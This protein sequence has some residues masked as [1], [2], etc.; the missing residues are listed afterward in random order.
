MERSEGLILWL[1]LFAYFVIL[2]SA[3]LSEP[4]WK[5][6][7]RA[8]LAVSL[9]VA[10]FGVGQG[11]RL[12]FLLATSGTR[13][14][15]TFGNPAFL[16]GYLLFHIA[17]AL[18]LFFQ[19]T[20]KAVKIY[21]LAL[22]VL[23]TWVIFATETRG[24]AVGLAAGILLAS[25]L[26]AW[27]N[28]QNK[29]VRNWA[30]GIIILVIL[31]GGALYLGRGS[32]FVKNSPILRRLASISLSER[33]AQTRLATWRAGWQG[34]REH[35]VLGVGMENF[36]IVFNKN[37]PTIIYE[38]EG[39]Q[40]WFDRAH[41]VIFDR[42]V[43]TGALGLALYLVFLFYPVWL[44]FKVYR[45]DPKKRNGAI[46]FLAL[47]IAY[48]IQDLFI[49]ETI[50]T[51]VLLFFTMAFF[52]AS[53]LPKDAPAPAPSGKLAYGIIAVIYAVLLGPVLWT[54]NIL[55]ARANLTA[56]AALRIE[57]KAEN[58][59]PITEQ[60]K[61][62]L[63]LGTYGKKEY[64]V[65]YIDFVG[66]QLANL[67]TV[68]EAVKP[69]VADIDNQVA[70]QLA[71]YPYDAKNYLVAMRHYN[72]TNAIDPATVIQRLEKA[73]S[74][75]EKLKNLTPS[76]PHVY[77]EAGYTHLYLAR[78]YKEQ[79]QLDLSDE[80]FKIAEAMFNQT[81]ALNPRVTES[82]RN[83]IMLY[84]SLG[85]EDKVEE[86]IKKM[87][88]VKVL[89]TDDRDYAS[90]SDLAK[91]SNGFR[92]VEY[93]SLERLKLN[94][95]N[96]NAWIDLALSYAYRGQKAKAIEIANKITSFGDAYAGEVDTFIKNVNSGYYNQKR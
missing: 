25:A 76:R 68:S 38:D 36:N 72:Y 47:I 8:S 7:L 15:A 43:T 93:L 13:V 60:Y 90:L 94:E 96:V 31:A 83:L 79:N 84:F 34:W 91:S 51:Y 19:T 58:F 49:F 80:H 81:V 20:S 41:N 75:F 85:Q 78:Y 4:A 48:F 57:E 65:K 40:V 17:F 59:F 22:P 45:D 29:R 37:F 73:L 54:V 14:D 11:L 46:I 28:R 2:V 77:Q 88:E 12:D 23:F 89:G 53:V 24:A 16:A 32:A 52:A 71:E 27:S 5:N 30:V 44:F 39:S 82:F 62:T 56:A 69:V 42:G 33:T 70:L 6:L 50:V 9:L 18:Y 64:R 55:P 35:L 92:T 21:Y 87:K 1:H 95:S 66:W 3:V 74:F 86:T 63:E 26:L 10:L 61:K 67:G